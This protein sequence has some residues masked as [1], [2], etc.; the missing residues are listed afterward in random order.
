[1]RYDSRLIEFNVVSEE[2]TAF[3]I[4]DR[5]HRPILLFPQLDVT[6]FVIRATYGNLMQEKAVKCAK[7]NKW[8]TNESLRLVQISS[9]FPL[10]IR[11]KTA[12][13]Y[14]TEQRLLL[15]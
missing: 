14:A 3:K 15:Q 6:W 4:H 5:P 13:R 1:M 10:Q 2:T 8:I 9:K 12:R 11:S 7:K